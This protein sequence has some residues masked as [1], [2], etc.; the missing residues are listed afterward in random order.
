MVQAYNLDFGYLA[1]SD[2]GDRLFLGEL[3]QTQTQTG[4]GVYTGWL[5]MNYLNCKTFPCDIPIFSEKKLIEEMTL[6]D[7]WFL[8]KHLSI[9]LSK[10]FRESLKDIYSFLAKQALDQPQVFVHRDYH[11]RI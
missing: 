6:F 5:L 11:S 4:L 8:T 1:V 3:K 10:V 2:L 7:E 9:K